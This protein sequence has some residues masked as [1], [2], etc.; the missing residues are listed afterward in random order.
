MDNA[1]GAATI[2][3]LKASFPTEGSLRYVKPKSPRPCPKCHHDDAVVPITYGYPMPEWAETV[4]RGEVE[5]G[6]CLVGDI[7][8][9]FACRRCRISFKFTRPEMVMGKAGERGWIDE[10]DGPEQF[11]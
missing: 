7:D 4:E 10:M 6:G 8:P 1:Y 3:G 5:L 11:Q 2:S 9:N